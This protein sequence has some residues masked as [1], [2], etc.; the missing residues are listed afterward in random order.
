[1]ICEHETLWASIWDIHWTR[2]ILQYIK[3]MRRRFSEAGVRGVWMKTHCGLSLILSYQENRG[4]VLFNR[5]SV[6]FKTDAY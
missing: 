1:M 3:R 6:P 5:D 2:N 4:T